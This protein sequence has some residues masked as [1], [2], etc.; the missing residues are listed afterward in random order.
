MRAVSVLSATSLVWATPALAQ[1]EEF[2]FEFEDEGEDDATPQGAP[3]P[4]NNLQGGADPSV[5]S[6]RPPAT[7]PTGAPPSVTIDA[8]A[9]VLLGAGEEATL[10]LRFSQ[11]PKHPTVTSSV[12]RITNLTDRGGGRYSAQLLLPDETEQVLAFVPVFESRRWSFPVDSDRT[13][14][15]PP[16]SSCSCTTARAKPR[17]RT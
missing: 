12:G 13:G 8:P 9:S 1:E 16:R 2:N 11:A 5:R 6:S 10:E 3:S 14:S 4:D 15:A 17:T 7:P